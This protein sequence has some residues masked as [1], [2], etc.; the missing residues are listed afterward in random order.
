MTTI[1]EGQLVLEEIPV[2]G[3]H[4]VVRA[5]DPKSG[6]DAI[7][8]IHDLRL[9]KAAL[10]GTRIHKYSTFEEHLEDAL[11]LSKGMTYKSAAVQSGFGGGKAVIN[12]DP[13][14][15]KTEALLAAFGEAVNRLGGEYICAE[16]VGCLPQDLATVVEHTPYAVGLLS[17]K[18]SGNPSP[19]T[20]WGVFR[21]IQA[22]MH[23]LFGDDSVQ[24][25]TIAIQGL[26]SVGARLAEFLYWHGAKLIITDFHMDRAEGLAKQ[27]SAKLVEPDAIYEEPCD[28]FAPC[29]MGAIIN[30]TT[31][32][33]LRCRAIA[34]SANNQLLSDLDAEEL[35]R[36]GFLYAPDFVINAGGLINVT[37]ETMKNG[38]CPF[39]SRNKIDQIY[40]QLRLI[41]GVASQ[42]GISTLKAAM[43]LIEYRLEHG[44]GR[45]VEPIYMHHAGITY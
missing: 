35:R 33:R 34:G 29:A 31:I 43:Q 3:Y 5:R 20:A 8:A 39:A 1:L 23:Q 28:V 30:S 21:G 7:I 27:F 45:R 13:R 16:D 42:N 18:S 26:G 37:E 12:A 2:E 24:G 11:R 19:Y 10:G 9:G 15:D 40:D 44:I 14:K 41:F 22:V 25:R 17:E 4:K 38:Y 6:L 32:E 36:L